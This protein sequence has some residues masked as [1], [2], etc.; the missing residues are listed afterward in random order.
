MCYDYEYVLIYYVRQLILF[1]KYQSVKVK[2]ALNKELMLYLYIY[3]S[4]F[5]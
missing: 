5:K 3:A 4:D 1:L 2:R